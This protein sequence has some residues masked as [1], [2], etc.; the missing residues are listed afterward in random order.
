MFIVYMLRYYIEV[1][2]YVSIGKIL[3]NV[4]CVGVFCLVTS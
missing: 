3:R 1:F 2:Y 4:E